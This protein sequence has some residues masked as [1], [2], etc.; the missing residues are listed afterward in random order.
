M[1]KA[2]FLAY[3]QQLMG[4]AVKPLKF[5]VIPYKHEGSTYGEDSIRLTGSKEFIE[6]VLQRLGPADLLANENLTTRLQVAYQQVKD[7]QGVLIDGAFACYIQVHERGGDAQM[8][9]QMVGKII[10][11]SY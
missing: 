11:S 4:M 9:N 6:A 10:S 8:A 5:A 3:L 1:K 7:K 2:Q